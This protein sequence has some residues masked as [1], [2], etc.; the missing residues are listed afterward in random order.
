MTSPTPD[1]L[2]AEAS[3]QFSQGEMQHAADLLDQAL[4]Q[5][6]NHLYALYNRAQI[7]LLQQELDEA[8]S[9]FIRTLEEEPT[10]TPAAIGL[11]KAFIGHKSFDR[12]LD[13]LLQLEP[14]L[15]PEQLVEY[16]YLAGICHAGEREW[17]GALIAFEH[18]ARLRPDSLDPQL[19]L[20][21]AH[22]NLG[23]HTEALACLE[24]IADRDPTQ[25]AVW[26]TL[27][28]GL[29]EQKQTAR[30]LHHCRR[31][32]EANADRIELHNLAVRVCV[33]SGQYAHAYLLCRKAIEQ[34]PEFDRT[35]YIALARTEVLA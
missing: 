18:Y 5:A 22:E 30:V 19:C 35:Q 6:P 27:L 20:Y 24:K 16:H 28:Q 31:M 14:H 34:H 2:V 13:A 21:R 29:L 32:T 15:T 23:N 8:E 9:V 3:Q 26:V 7:H 11:T 33:E 4:H 17:D 25:S 10:F 1:S 12:A